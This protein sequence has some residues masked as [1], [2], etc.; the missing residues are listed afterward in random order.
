MYDYMA[1]DKHYKPYNFL[2]KYVATIDG[3]EMF[4]QRPSN[5]TTQKSS[6]DYKSHTMVK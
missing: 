1:T 2:T 6:S 5:F 3:T 4:I